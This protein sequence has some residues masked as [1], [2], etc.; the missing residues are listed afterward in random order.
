M[1]QTSDNYKTKVYEAR[2]MHLL[3]IYINDT[4]VD[5]KHV[6]D[7]K[8]SQQLFSNDEFLLGSVTS[9]A[10][11]LKLH[12][13]AVPERIEKVYIESGITG[14]VIPIGIFNLEEISKVDDYTITLKLLD[15]MIRFEFN[16]DGSKLNY[17]CTILTVL[18][19]ICSKA[20]VEL[21]FYFF[22]KYE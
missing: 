13:N 18:R 8:L 7:C 3:N 10:V 12:K 9:Q 17:P 4:K 14:E 20:E 22:F 2:T 21:R 11:E 19:E 1:Y 16:Y 15:N 5:D 6:L